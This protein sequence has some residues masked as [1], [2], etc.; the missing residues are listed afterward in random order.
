MRLASPW[1]LFK[2]LGRSGGP[3]ATTPLTALAQGT[4]GVPSDSRPPS[5]KV[6]LDDSRFLPIRA[7]EGAAGYDLSSSETVSIPASSTRC[8]STGIRIETPPDT[9][10]RI[11]DRSSVAKKGVTVSGGVID[12]DY[13]GIIKVILNNNGSNTY[14]IESGDKIAQLILERHST[15]D[16]SIEPILTPTSRDN[17]GFGSTNPSRPPT[18]P[19]PIPPAT[20]PTAPTSSPSS[21]SHDNETL[22]QCL[23][24]A[25]TADNAANADPQQSFTLVFKSKGQ[26]V[27][28]T[29]DTGAYSTWMDKS[30]YHLI[31]YTRMPMALPQRMDDK[32]QWQ[33]LVFSLLRSSADASA[34]PFA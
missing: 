32:S 12:A 11:A 9:Y 22:C 26:K 13:R 18:P 23:D 21:P 14:H 16:T 20:P 27:R 8:I 10:G 4:S 2:K 25:D 6:Q 24:D 1:S 7:T 33:V 31:L 29:V 28:G 5:L 30:L 19:R 15:P 34:N 17:K 3:S